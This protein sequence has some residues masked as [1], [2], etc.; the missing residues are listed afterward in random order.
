MCGIAGVLLVLLAQELKFLEQG[1]VLAVLFLGWS[2]CAGALALAVSSPL[3][4]MV[5][6]LHA[7]SRRRQ[8]EAF[9]EQRQEQIRKAAEK[10]MQRNR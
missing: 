9:I 8:V 6:E 1:L 10:A 3:G 2:L 7:V 5:G 4:R